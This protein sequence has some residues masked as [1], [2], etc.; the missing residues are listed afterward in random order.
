MLGELVKAEEAGLLAIEALTKFFI[1]RAKLSTK[2][3]P[4]IALTCLC[5]LQSTRSMPT[6]TPTPSTR[7]TASS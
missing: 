1:H 7:T 6:T 5:R 4:L 3:P 2:A